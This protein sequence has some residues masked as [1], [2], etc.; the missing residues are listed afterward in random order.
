MAEDEEMT[1]GGPSSAVVDRAPAT[2]MWDTQSCVPL[3]NV[4][5]KEDD[6]I[7]LL[8]PVVVHPDGNPNLTTDPFES[9]GR[10]LAERHP[11]I[12]HVPYTKRGGITSTHVAFIKRAAV[13]IFVVSGLPRHE[14]EP[15]QLEFA[16]VARV[17][18]EH[19]T[20]V[21][22]AC[23]DF[24]QQDVA[25]LGIHTLV[26]CD[27]YARPELEAA[28]GVFFGQRWDSA[29]SSPAVTLPLTNV[30]PHH[31]HGLPIPM[32]YPNASGPSHWKPEVWDLNHGEI[33]PIHA[34]WEMCM[35]SQFCLT[36]KRLNSVLRRLGYSTHYIVRTP[37]GQM[38]GFCATFVN[39]LAP[40][41]PDYMGSIAMLLVHPDFRRQG[42]GTAMHDYAYDQLKNTPKVVR[43]QL[44]ST[45]PRILYGVPSNYPNLSW[46]RRLGWEIDFDAP[47]K[48]RVV[49][50]WVL[51]FEDLPGNEFS[52]AGLT[53]KR[54]EPA[55]FPKVVDLVYY[56][57]KRKEN[58][59]WP[60]TYG[61]LSPETGRNP[62]NIIVGMEGST[63]VTTALIYVPNDGVPP[64]DDL[65]WAGTI[66]SDV[67]GVTCIC[68]NDTDPTLVVRPDAI[69][70]RLLDTCV[71]I[72]TEKGMR[73]LF[74]DGTR[75][76]EQGFLS[77]GFR[78]WA[79]YREVWKD[80]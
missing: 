8:T 48:G 5:R 33:A 75:G 73:K 54:C 50:D 57:S 12:R 36:P 38:I 69:M 4:L 71:R 51:N 26:H 2:L 18:S 9:F 74:I 68:I 21:L 78:K 35:P 32:P 3:T 31:H 24:E 63:I 20:F 53:F 37:S 47:G 17:V 13:V 65:P 40:D 46:F 62:N 6:L 27:G 28:A 70:I 42:I 80:L 15:S 59:G 45:F 76:G 79:S 55:E 7:V 72:L 67:G 11:M 56:A 25:H 44:G 14:D 30:A 52:S 43:I 29:P 64:D 49:T 16:D 58:L 19:R 23:Y 66:G 1:E 34:L 61:K 77:L 39:Y 22:L 60:D 41:S 10:A